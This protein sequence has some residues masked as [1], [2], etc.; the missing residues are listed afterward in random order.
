MAIR[1]NITSA[2][3]LTARAVRGLIAA[4]RVR[5]PISLSYVRRV[6][7]YPIP[8]YSRFGLYSQGVFSL[9]CYCV[10]QLWPQ[11]W[12]HIPGIAI[13][14]LG[15]E[16]VIITLRA[17]HEKFGKAEQVMWLAIAF[18]LFFVEVR[19][20][21][22]DR[23][24]R[25]RE[26]ATER[27]AENQQFRNIAD[28]LGFS[29]KKSQAQFNATMLGLSENLKTVTGGDSFC[30]LTLAGNDPSPLLLV[31]SQGKY[32]LHDVGVR[33]VDLQKFNRLTSTGRPL[34]IETVT[35]ADTVYN[36]GDL[37]RTTSRIIGR[38]NINEEPG[39]KRDFNIF[40]SGMN[41]FWS[42]QLR[43]RRVNGHWLRAFKVTRDTTRVVRGPPRSNRMVYTEIYRKIDPGFPPMKSEDD[44]K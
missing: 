42:E 29:I 33:L 28:S 12:P 37:P 11:V 23:N 2:V 15:V 16:A 32:P 19:T 18:V 39:D 34:T 14:V 40:F 7:L 43:M 5:L 36:I 20:T 9:G 38:L 13:A 8:H 10:Y 35:G 4:L 26:Q 41:G 17:G 27:Q 30:F 22:R 31:V 3:A 44:W 25:D 1:Q 24:E 21:I 6:A